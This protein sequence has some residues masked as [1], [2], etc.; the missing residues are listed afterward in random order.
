MRRAEE[1]YGKV[2]NVRNFD[3]QP[4]LTEMDALIAYLQVL[5]TMVDFSTFTPIRAAKGGRMD[6]YSFLRELAD[7]WGLLALTRCSSLAV[8]V[9]G[10]CARAAAAHDDAANSIFRNDSQASAGRQP[11]PTARVKE[12]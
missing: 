3:G 2:V 12:A 6:T 11:R 8:I 1:R 9:S 4:Q 10:R 5:G 7:S